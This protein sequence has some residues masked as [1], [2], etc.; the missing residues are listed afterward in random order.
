M[1]VKMQTARLLIRPF[2]EADLQDYFEIVSNEAVAKAAGF[3]RARDLQEARYL[4]LQSI[5]QG[6][7]YAIVL[8]ELN[9]VVGSVGLYDHLNREGLPSQRERDLGYV[10]NATFW[11]RGYMTEAGQAVLAYAVE[12]LGVTIIWASFIDDNQA[13][14]AVLKK[15]GFSYDST[16]QHAATASF[17]PDA[18]EVFYRFTAE[19]AKKQLQTRISWL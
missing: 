9:K 2:Q 1:G 13:S 15:L 12:K 16:Y 11:N 18:K 17:L 4:L 3:H 6:G 14:R 7:V 19:S 10:M 8:T 5:R